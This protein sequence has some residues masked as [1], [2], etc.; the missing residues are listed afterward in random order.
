MLFMSFDFGS[1]PSQVSCHWPGLAI[2]FENLMASLEKLKQKKVSTSCSLSAIPVSNGSI[3][4]IICIR[5]RNCS[6]PETDH[7]IFIHVNRVLTGRTDGGVVVVI[8]D[9]DV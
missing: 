2:S 8:S 6:Q 7:L 1:G 4:S 5:A 3:R 9:G